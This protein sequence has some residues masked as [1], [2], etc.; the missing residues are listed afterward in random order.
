VWRASQLQAPMPSNQRL[1]TTASCIESEFT[2]L[3]RVV[4][5]EQIRCQQRSQMKLKDRVGDVRCGIICY[6]AKFMKLFVS[7]EPGRS[8]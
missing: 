7:E 6:Y 2:Q 1:L 8:C 4:E 3:L 5:V